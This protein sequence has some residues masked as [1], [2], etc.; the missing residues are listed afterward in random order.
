M[1]EV[2]HPQHPEASEAPAPGTPSVARG[3]GRDQSYSSG[4]RHLG[5]G[6]EYPQSAWYPTTSESEPESPSSN[7]LLDAL[8]LADIP[9]RVQPIHRPD[10]DGDRAADWAPYPTRWRSESEF[11]SV[12]GTTCERR[13][14]SMIG[15]ADSPA[16]R[17][18][19]L[20]IEASPEDGHVDIRWRVR[21]PESRFL[22]GLPL[23]EP[24]VEYNIQAVC[25]T[26]IDQAD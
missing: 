23:Y 19:Q 11:P 18:V 8:T 17:W 12:V 24:V 6:V 25:G 7:R 1:S 14:R 2:F 4:P 10:W 15:G 13:R 20:S 5:E 26:A 3:P 9:K 21:D 16:F 22:A